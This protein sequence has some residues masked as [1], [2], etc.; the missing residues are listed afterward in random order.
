MTAAIASRERRL[1]P[2]EVAADV[3]HRD[4]HGAE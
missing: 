2:G 3:E 4:V 1:Q